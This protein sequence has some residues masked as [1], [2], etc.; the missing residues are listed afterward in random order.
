[1]SFFLNSVYFNKENE[2]TKLV[3][4]FIE[5]SL[6]CLMGEETENHVN[7]MQP[8]LIPYPSC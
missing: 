6:I 5:R 2:Q 8:M 1:M 3:L 4:K 7:F